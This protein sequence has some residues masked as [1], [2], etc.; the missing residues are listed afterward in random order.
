MVISN[1][2]GV[3]CI[4]EIPEIEQIPKDYILSGRGRDGRSSGNQKKGYSHPA[5]SLV[6]FWLGSRDSNP[7]W[8]ES[9]SADLPLV[10]SP[11]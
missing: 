5:V 3:C 1:E 8:A 6:I 9:E 7:E 2:I 4:K 11:V 10:N